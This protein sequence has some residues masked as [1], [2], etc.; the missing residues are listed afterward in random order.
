MEEA[1]RHK[2]LEEMKKREHISS[3]VQKNL[4]SW[5]HSG[6]SVFVG[7]PIQPDE[8]ERLERLARYVRRRVGILIWVWLLFDDSPGALRVKSS[9][10]LHDMKAP[11]FVEVPASVG[12]A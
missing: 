12:G 6:F 7:A 9:L 4:L 10:F 3:A 5:K 11:I 8:P 1:F 2:V